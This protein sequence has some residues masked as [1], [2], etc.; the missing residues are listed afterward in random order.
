MRKN[1]KKIVLDHYC[2]LV[3][4]TLQY[5]YRPAA[6]MNKTSP[7]SAQHWTKKWVDYLNGEEMYTWGGWQHSTF[8]PEELQDVHESILTLLMAN[9]ES[10][11]EDVR[12]FL[13]QVYDR[14]N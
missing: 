6:R 8:H 7:S 12:E 1:Q 4:D 10:C 3:L 5:G 13:E 14:Y 2:K 9:P 11:L